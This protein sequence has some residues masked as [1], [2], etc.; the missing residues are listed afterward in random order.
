MDLS[1][2]TSDKM[3]SLNEAIDILKEDKSVLVITG[4]SYINGKL[5]N[6]N[7]SE[8]SQA[9]TIKEVLDL[10]KADDYELYNLHS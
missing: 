6:G 5:V 10:I 8:I 4:A 1:L 2:L 3:I 7:V 9:N